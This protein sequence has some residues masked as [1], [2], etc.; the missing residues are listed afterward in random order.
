MTEPTQPMTDEVTGQTSV[1]EKIHVAF[2]LDNNYAEG[3]GVAVYSLCKN[4]T[5][6]DEVVIHIVMSEALQQR[7]R[8]KFQQLE[9]MFAPRVE[10][11]I[12]DSE[13]YIRRLI[14]KF[15]HTTKIGSIPF[16]ILIRIALPE[17]L[18]STINKVIN[19]DCDILIFTSLRDLWNRLPDEDHV[20]ACVA[21][22]FYDIHNDYDHD[23]LD[24]R[25]GTV[26]H[27]IKLLPWLRRHHIP[28]Q[29]PFYISCGMTIWDLFRI[30]KSQRLVN[31]IIDFMLR[32]KPP[33]TDQDTLTIVLR[34]NV[35][36]CDNR[37]NVCFYGSNP[38]KVWFDG[39]LQ[40][41]EVA[42]L[43]YQFRPKPWKIKP[44]E[45]VKTHCATLVK[46]ITLRPTT[47][48]HRYRQGSPW[49]HS[50]RERF[51][52][53]FATPEDRKLFKP[54]FTGI[55]AALMLTMSVSFYYLRRFFIS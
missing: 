53:L 1:P 51:R 2:C 46:Y 4:M 23:D 3:T 13:E 30:R 17:I 7:H 20:L 22:D 50:L 38:Y 45:F 14:N 8:R 49:K 25:L 43:H 34:N 40:S 16:S 9:R 27:P 35:L 26:D 41:R 29:M 21:R 6:E 11:K 47:I 39:S 10:I 44:Y 12:Y 32:Y 54:I 37:W 48:W 55:A 42:I 28:V 18:P 36:L 33:L 15:K 24:K 31:E 5:P 52:E 19:F